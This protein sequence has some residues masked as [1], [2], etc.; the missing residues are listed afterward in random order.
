M[1]RKHCINCGCELNSPKHVLNQRYCSKKECQGTRRKKWKQS[2][3]KDDKAYKV[4]CKK[5]QRKWRADNPD[6]QSKWRDRNPNYWIQRRK[7]L[8]NK[9]TLHKEKSQKIKILVEKNVLADL[10]KMGEI[11]CVCQMVLVS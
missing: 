4:Y 10:V 9:S 7:R 6:Y 1:N 3:L 11:N 2:K 5:T 8:A